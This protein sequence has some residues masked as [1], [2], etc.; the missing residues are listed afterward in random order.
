MIR[1]G[2]CLGYQPYPPIDSEFLRRL[3]AL[4]KLSGKKD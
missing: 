3:D 2:S 1:Y 4:F